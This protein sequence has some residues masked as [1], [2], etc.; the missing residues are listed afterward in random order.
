MDEFEALLNLLLRV[1]QHQ[2]RVQL[3]LAHSVLR[4]DGQLL[5]FEL[6]PFFDG[7][8]EDGLRLLVA[9][10]ALLFELFEVDAPLLQL[11]TQ[12]GLDLRKLGLLLLQQRPFA[13]VNIRAQL[14]AQLD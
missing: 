12:L 11:Q 9:L 6:H 8:M 5:S 2:S 4:L 13:V 7:L 1:L 3:R 14:L 10:V